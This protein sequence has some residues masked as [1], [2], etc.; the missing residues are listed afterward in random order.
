[1][2]DSPPDHEPLYTAL[3]AG[4]DLFANGRVV[5]QDECEKW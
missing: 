4:R 1:M 5:F 3:E 2:T